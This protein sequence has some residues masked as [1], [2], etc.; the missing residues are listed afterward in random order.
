ME[1]TSLGNFLHPV[2]LI[3]SG[4]PVLQA[5]EFECSILDE[6]DLDVEKNSV[7]SNREMV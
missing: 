4:K 6:V 5:G 1:G 3:G 7:Y 2:Q